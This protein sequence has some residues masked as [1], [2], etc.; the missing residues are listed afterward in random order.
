MYSNSIRD[1]L[2]GRLRILKASTSL[3]CNPKILLENN[4]KLVVQLQRSL[5]LNMKKVVKAE[6]IKL[7]DVGVI[8]QI[9]NGS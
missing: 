8:Y 2:H 5:N 7:L 3:F 1:Q 9:T 6:V 4:F